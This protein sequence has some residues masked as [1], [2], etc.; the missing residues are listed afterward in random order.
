MGPKQP[1]ISII[2]P[3]YTY[4]RYLPETLKS[5]LDQTFSDWECVLVANGS[6]ALT[7]QVIQ[8][9]VDKDS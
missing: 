1:E 5:L 8:V 6:D 3:C 2:I 9:F 7:L 4:G